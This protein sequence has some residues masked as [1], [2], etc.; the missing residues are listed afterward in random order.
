VPASY[1]AID[2]EIEERKS[3]VREDRLEFIRKI[4]GIL[5]TQCLIYLTAIVAV[6]LNTE[7]KETLKKF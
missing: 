5:A 6:Q 1:G 4:Y 3:R 7:W 2:K